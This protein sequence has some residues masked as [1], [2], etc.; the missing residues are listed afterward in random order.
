MIDKELFGEVDVE[1]SKFAVLKPKVEIT[2]VKIVKDQWSSLEH[3]C[4]VFRIELCCSCNNLCDCCCSG[5]V[6][7]PRA[8]APVATVEETVEMDVDG[9]PVINIVSQRQCLFLVA[10][11]VIHCL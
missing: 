1:K 6:R 2:L 3:R 10:V 5:A 7:L 11:D 4:V 8:A 9:N